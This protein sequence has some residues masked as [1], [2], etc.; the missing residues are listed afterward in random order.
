MQYL[1]KYSD[2]AKKVSTSQGD[3]AA[4]GPPQSG[5]LVKKPGTGQW[6]PEADAAAR[7]IMDPPVPRR[8]GYGARNRGDAGLNPHAVS[9]AALIEVLFV[10]RNYW[11]LVESIVES[12]MR[13]QSLS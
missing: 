7:K 2:A 12:R 4:A 13:R 8:H 9:F 3:P 11:L 6:E 5:L 1:E 10:R